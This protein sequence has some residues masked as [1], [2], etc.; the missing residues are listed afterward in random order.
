M[1]QMLGVDES[2]DRLDE[3]GA[4]GEEDREHDGQP[5]EPLATNAAEEEGDSEWDRCQRVAEVVNQIR[6]ECYRVGEG[7]DRDLST[8]CQAEDGQAERDR[9]D[10]GV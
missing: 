10:A 5:G 9:V 4:G 3:G 7:D 8:G 6:E 1:R 2:Q